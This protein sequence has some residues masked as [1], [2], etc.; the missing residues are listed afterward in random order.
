MTEIEPIHIVYRKRNPKFIDLII[1]LLAIV[2]GTMATLGLIN[3][4]SH[5]LFSIK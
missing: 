3:L 1:E 5:H 2:G 4:A